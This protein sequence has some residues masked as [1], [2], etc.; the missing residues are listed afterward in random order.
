MGA[1]LRKGDYR[2]PKR[3]MLGELENTGKR[4]GRGGR[5]GRRNNNGRNAWQR[6]VGYLASRG[7]GAP[8][9]LTLGSVTAQYV[10][11]AVGLWPRG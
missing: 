6:I 8:P 5:G 4:A 9:H 1:L 7:P 2:L 3:V 10:K 11:E